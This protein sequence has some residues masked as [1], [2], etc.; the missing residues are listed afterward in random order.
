MPTTLH[1]RPFAGLPDPLAP[2]PKAWLGYSPKFT[3]RPV[4]RVCSWCPDKIEAERQAHAASHD[5]THCICPEHYQK[6]IA[7]LFGEQPD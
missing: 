4:V 3:D 1:P 7:E 6:Q 2:L 5:I